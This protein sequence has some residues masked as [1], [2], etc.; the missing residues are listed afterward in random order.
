MRIPFFTVRWAAVLLTPLAAT[1]VPL[2]AGHLQEP[3]SGGGFPHQSAIR[4]ELTAEASQVLQAGGAAFP[5]TDAGF[6]AY[7]RVPSAGGGFALDK[8]AV[9]QAL[10][11]RPSPTSRRAGAATLRQIGDNYTIATVRIWNIDGLSSDVGLY[12]DV[13]G[14]VVAYLPKGAAPSQGWQAGD[15]DHENPRLQDVSV[16]TLL[17]VINEVLASVAGAALLTPGQVGYYHWQH[18]NATNFVMFATALGS[19]D[20]DSVFFAVPSGF[21]LHEASASLWVSLTGGA[22]ARASLDAVDLMGDRCSRSFTHHAVDLAGLSPGAVHTLT[23]EQ[24]NPKAGAAGL[25]GMLIYSTPPDAVASPHPADITFGSESGEGVPKAAF[26]GAAAGPALA[27]PPEA[28]SRIFVGSAQ[29]AHAG[30]LS[31]VVISLP[32]L[33]QGVVRLQGQ[34][35]SLGGYVAVGDQVH[36]LDAGG[37]F[38]FPW[39]S[40]PADVWIKAPGHLP[41]LIPQADVAA[42]AVLTIPELTLP[43]G[44]ANGD[45]RIDV[46]DLGMAAANFGDVTKPVPLPH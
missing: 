20:T 41:V 28:L 16:T 23:L 22:C 35:N 3:L 30:G 13:Q 2:L 27:T 32:G 34:P 9:D 25:L 26:S 21:T 15:L 24:L 4:L 43:F 1:F 36:F 33:V 18:P 11:A 10:L 31:P 19:M 6:S 5:A 29:A 38:S 45:G 37:R 12:Y 39:G 17:N 40:G 14:W 46:L 8:A 7:H 42:G 44:D